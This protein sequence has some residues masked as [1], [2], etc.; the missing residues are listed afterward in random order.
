MTSNHTTSQPR[1]RRRSRLITALFA[2]AVMSMLSLSSAAPSMA[3]EKNQFPNQRIVDVALSLPENSFGDECY[4]FV[5]RVVAQASGGRVHIGGAHTYYGAYAREGGV[6]VSA[7]QAQPGDIIQ[8]SV[9]GDD[10]T[11]H[12]GMHTAVVVAN[13]GGGNFDV[14][15]SNW[16]LP[17]HQVHHHHWNPDRSVQ[18]GESVQIWRMGQA[19]QVGP[20]PTIGQPPQNPRTPLAPVAPRFQGNGQNTFTVYGLKPGFGLSIRS[21]PGLEYPRV[22]YL[23]QG[24]PVAIGCQTQ[25]GLALGS[26]IWDEIGPGQYVSDWFIN[27]PGVNAFTSGLK[28]CTRSA[29]RGPRRF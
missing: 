5:N 27:T 11:Y 26:T 4:L 6:Q 14:V 22:G 16:G 12:D 8:I 21:G 10:G 7:A 3:S 25:G 29:E 1:G 13:L 19:G 20:E 17:H 28:Q 23:N 24:D 9:P 2:A 18:A 15:D